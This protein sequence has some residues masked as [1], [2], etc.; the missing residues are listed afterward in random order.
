MWV[1][2]VIPQF[3]VNSKFKTSL[4]SFAAIFLSIFL[5]ISP[6]IWATITEYSAQNLHWW[7]N[8]PICSLELTNWRERIYYF[9]TF[10][11]KVTPPPSIFLHLHLP[12]FHHLLNCLEVNQFLRPITFYLL[13]IAAMIISLTLQNFHYL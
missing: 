5:S 1:H 13:K 2:N 11:L 12:T 10:V 9:Y 4:S 8:S 7:S 6:W 3:P